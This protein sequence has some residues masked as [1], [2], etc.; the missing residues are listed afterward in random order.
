MWDDRKLRETCLE[1]NHPYFQHI[2]ISQ[3]RNGSAYKAKKIPGKIQDKLPDAT[4][5]NSKT[6][7][8][9]RKRWIQIHIEKGI[10]NI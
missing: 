5:R 9:V 10:C 3:K 1:G 8:H 6:E 2:K 4:S 7:Q